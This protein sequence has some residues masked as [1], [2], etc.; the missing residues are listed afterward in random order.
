ML[1]LLQTLC[2]LSVATAAFVC[3][4]HVFLAIVAIFTRHVA[5]R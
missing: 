3:L 2:I 4:Y 5:S 1:L